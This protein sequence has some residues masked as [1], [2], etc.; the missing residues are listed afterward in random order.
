MP[1]FVSPPNVHPSAAAVTLMKS[2]KKHARTRRTGT[3]QNFYKPIPKAK[4]LAH[5]VRNELN[6]TRTDNSAKVASFVTAKSPFFV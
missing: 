3:Q 2:S 5:Q 1:Q 4:K 6:K